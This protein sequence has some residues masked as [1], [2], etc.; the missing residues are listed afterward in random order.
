MEHLW[1][2]GLVVMS[3]VG[4]MLVEDMPTQGDQLP[5]IDGTALPSLLNSAEI[6]LIN[7]FINRQ[8][9][10]RG[11]TCLTIFKKLVYHDCNSYLAGQFHWDVAQQRILGLDPRLLKNEHIYGYNLFLEVCLA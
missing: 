11:L 2:V 3:N 9:Y 6:F 8:A 5:S 4:K 10:M 1:R 7:W